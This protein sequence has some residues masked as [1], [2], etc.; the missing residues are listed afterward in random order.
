MSPRSQ[1]GKSERPRSELCC[2]LAEKR[3]RPPERS[4]AC[5]RVKRADNTSINASRR[6]PNLCNLP[7]QRYRNDIPLLSLRLR[8][9]YKS[10]LRHRAT[11]S[12]ISQSERLGGKL[13]RGE[14]S[15]VLVGAIG[16]PKGQ[17]PSAF[18][19]LK[20]RSRPLI[21]HRASA[22]TVSRETRQSPHVPLVMRTMSSRFSRSQVDKRS[23]AVKEGAMRAVSVRTS[24]HLDVPLKLPSSRF[25]LLLAYSRRSESISMG[26][27]GVF[28][29]IPRLS[30]A[31]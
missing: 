31:R 2:S 5:S 21:S 15:L 1:D 13:T 17:N 18:E 9:L 10:E 4:S 24:A 7:K 30:D 6:A 23:R 8:R 26:C 22:F 12:R 14:G 25:V 19:F 11:D 16:F 29:V 28:P 27:L 20:S 3:N